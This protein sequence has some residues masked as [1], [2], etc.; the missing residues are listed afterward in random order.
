MF[1]ELGPDARGLLEAAAFFPRGV[2]EKNIDRL[3][4]TISDGPNMFDKFCALSLI[5]RSNGSITMLA[6]LRDY[7]RPKDLTTSPLLGTAKGCYLT[8]LSV[9]LDPDRPGFSEAQWM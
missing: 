8:R 2:N 3:F 7:V 6:P 5:C 9:E 1:Q 4:P